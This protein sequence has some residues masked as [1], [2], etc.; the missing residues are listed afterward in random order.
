MAKK[1][2]SPSAR[3]GRPALKPG[4]PKR[5]S[6]NTRLRAE[7]K[8]QL[9]TEAQNAGRSLSEEIEMRLE[10]SFIEDMGSESTRKLMRALALAKEMAEM[11]TGKNAF[12][13]KA[14]AQAAHTA[15]TAIL[16]SILPVGAVPAKDQIEPSEG[17]ETI[18]R[19]PQGRSLGDNIR[20]A[21]LEG[22][23]P[24]LSAIR[25]SFTPKK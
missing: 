17:Q 5:G 10:Q 9:E 1:M 23:G 21:I 8:Q 12:R 6:F 25:S 16:N 13:D 19:D 22:L 7:I 11:T 18:L 24:N 4:S 3:R 14:T 2:K 15:M 20:D